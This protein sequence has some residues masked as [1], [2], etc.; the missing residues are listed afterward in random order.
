[1]GKAIIT[2]ITGQDGTCLAEFILNKG[3]EVYGIKRRTSLLNTQW[4]NHFY[5]DP[6]IPDRH[7]VLHYGDIT[8]STNLIRFV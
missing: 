8:D 3:Y 7:F 4:I 5:E 2:G 1:M 6:Y